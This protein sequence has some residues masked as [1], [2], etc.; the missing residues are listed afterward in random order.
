MN[1]CMLYM[2]HYTTD[3]YILPVR[4]GIHIHLYGI[5]EESVDEDRMIW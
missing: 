5:F 4:D 1:A 2:F 3:Y